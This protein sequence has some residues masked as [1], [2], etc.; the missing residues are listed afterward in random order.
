MGL[1]KKQEMIVKW[2]ESHDDKEEWFTLEQIAKGM[3]I[4]PSTIETSLDGLVK[5]KF[6]V[7]K[8]DAGRS[9]FN[10]LNYI[11]KKT[12]WRNND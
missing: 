5:R 10:R 1:G 7:K 8:R 6:V 2:L 12:D 4:R 9:I 11:S 3:K